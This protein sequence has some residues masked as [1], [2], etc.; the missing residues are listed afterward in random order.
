MNNV[1]K[2]KR[3]WDLEMKLATHI[4]SLISNER[5]TVIELLH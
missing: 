2:Q 3:Y 5:L 4:A 1:V